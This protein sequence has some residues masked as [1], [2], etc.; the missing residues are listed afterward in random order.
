MK[1]LSKSSHTEEKLIKRCLKGESKSQKAL[2]DRYSPKMLAVCMRYTRDK[3]EAEDV[4]VQAFLKVF[5]KLDHYRGDGNF[6]GWIR[7]ITINE[8]LSN[9]RKNKSMP[10]NV[11]I[12]KANAETDL[13]HITDNL[14]VDDLFKLIQGMPAGYQ[15]VFNL[16]AIEGYSHAEIAE[17]LEIN[18]NTSK[19]Q[20]SRARM[21]LQ[22]KIK[23]MNCETKKVI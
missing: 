7:K 15:A 4:M 22:K 8:A 11:D 6:E 10:L 14:V 18:I 19:S 17:K 1:I 12:E 23:A 13:T 21:Y 20:L 9:L 16:Y 3:Q 2:Y 5:K